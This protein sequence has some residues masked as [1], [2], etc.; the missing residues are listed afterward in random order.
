MSVLPIEFRIVDEGGSMDEL[1]LEELE[2]LEKLSESVGPVGVEESSEALEGV[3][4]E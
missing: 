3:L 2:M 1:A 4:N